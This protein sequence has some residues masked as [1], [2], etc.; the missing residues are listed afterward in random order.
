MNPIGKSRLEAFSDGVIAILIT[1]MVLEL[2][3]PHEGGLE[4]VKPLMP[5]L[6]SY[7][8]SFIYLAIYWHNHHHLLHAAKRISGGVMWA[9]TH[10]LFWLSLFP[11]VTDWV[12]ETHGGRWPTVFYGF[13]F[14]MAAIAYYILQSAI[15][16]LEGE[17]SALRAAL[18]KDWKG[19]L[20]P[21]C[22]LAA[23][24]FAFVNPAVSIGIY[25]F[26]AAL[27]VIPDRRIERS[28]A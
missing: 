4:A 26:V 20:S 8:L 5:T 14:F 1:I 11:F 17:D 12:G 2:R 16:S 6:L 19:K 23:I 27:W 24:A 3:A 18:G 22:Y 10:L 15:L 13:V 28:V 9:N 25:V 7:L 21:F